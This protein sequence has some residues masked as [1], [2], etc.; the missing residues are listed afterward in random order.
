MNTFLFV[1]LGAFWGGSFVAIRYVLD[2]VTPLMGVS[3][4]LGIAYLVL[5]AF[6]YLRRQPLFVS[7]HERAQVWGAAFFAQALPFAALFWGETKISPGLA[8]IINGT[9]PIWS[10][11]LSAL[12][13]RGVEKV[14]VKKAMGILLG[15][16]GT[17]VIFLPKMEIHGSYDEILG[18]LAVLVMAISYGMGT[19]LNR[20]VLSGKVN[21]NA[22]TCEQLLFSSL[23]LLLI[24]VISGSAGPVPLTLSFLTAIIY[25]GLFSTAIAFL[26][27]YHLIGEWGAI[28]ASTVT[29]LIPVMAIL[30]DFLFFHHLPQSTELIGAAFILLGAFVIR[31]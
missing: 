19:V 26:I 14:S 29:Y 24:T 21:R 25:L 10:F 6:F 18:C 15:L 8:G 31:S 1:L 20:R 13:N 3:L 9:T 16:L 4:R 7:K 23:L 12:F 5:V 27:F 30:F 2:G 11:A 17:L 28:R 22:N